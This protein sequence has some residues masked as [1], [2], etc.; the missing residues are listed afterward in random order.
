MPV[1]TTLVDDLVA[2]G[3]LAVA[4]SM[5]LAGVLVFE[6][7]RQNK[8]KMATRKRVPPPPAAAA[9]MIVESASGSLSLIFSLFA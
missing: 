8:N 6:R 2:G 3:L 4:L 1:G 7:L 9:M 5:P